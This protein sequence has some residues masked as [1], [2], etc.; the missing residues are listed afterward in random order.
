MPHALAAIDV[1]E[2]S[3]PRDIPVQQP[4]GGP[5]STPPSADSRVPP[6]RAGS[7][8]SPTRSSDARWNVTVWA[9][10]FKSFSLA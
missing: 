5:Q 2:G 4:A 6:T 9:R 8:T 10:S 1:T 7:G 3:S